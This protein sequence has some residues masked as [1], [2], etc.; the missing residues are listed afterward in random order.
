MRPR[1]DRQGRRAGGGAAAGERLKGASIAFLILMALVVLQIAHYYPRVPDPMASH[2]VLD[3]S[4]NG[5][6]SRA[7][8][9]AIYLG[10][11]VL[12]AGVL[13]LLAGLLKRMPDRAVS[14]PNRD[15]WLSSDRRDGTLGYLQGAI[16]W[17]AIGVL[18]FLV[19]G[20]QLVIRAN[21]T[22][23]GHLE[24]R[25]LGWIAA[26]LVLWIVQTPLRVYVR[27]SKIPGPG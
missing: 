8:F 3:G 24:S 12:T 1:G 7:A 27:M 26:L 4:P 21:L 20:T 5:W 18:L 14:L 13:F 11:L 23:G 10:S 17:C 2:F 15:H 16:A 9:F 6:S 25:K 22:A 19:L